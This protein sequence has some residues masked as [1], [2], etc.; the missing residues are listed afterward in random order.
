MNLK[1]INLK[2]ILSVLFLL[3]VFACA[4]GQK[5]PNKQ[6]VSLRIPAGMKIDGA[7]DEWNNKFEAYNT[8]TSVFYSLA[9]DDDNLYLVMQAKD[10]HVI[11]KILSGGI[12]FRINSPVRSNKTTP[13][14]VTFPLLAMNDR[15]LISHQIAD[16]GANMDVALPAINSKLTM[17]SKEVAL[18]GIQQVTDT[19]ISVYNDYGI[20]TA[21]L[22]DNKKAYTYELALPRKYFKHLL[23]KETFNYD[24]ILNGAKINS[25]K[26]R[27]NGV[28]A[29][30]GSDKIADLVSKMGSGGGNS[31]FM[32]LTTPTD[33]S[34][35][36]TLAK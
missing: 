33:F 26:V 17:G 25:Y 30:A 5:L 11:E 9:N 8:N 19:L 10:I 2:P 35:S 36:Y 24:V 6:E 12:T 23:D 21:V 29:D 3:F 34:G 31:G 15:L 18:W 4:N 28:A 1:L 14:S 16:P 20:K 32:Y 22:F 13:V 27:I 7:A